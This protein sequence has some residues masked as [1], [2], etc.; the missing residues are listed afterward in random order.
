MSGEFKFQLQ[1]IVRH[2][3]ILIPPHSTG[4]VFAFSPEDL[5]PLLCGD[6]NRVARTIMKLQSPALLIRMVSWCSVLGQPIEKQHTAWVQR[7]QYILVSINI[8]TVSYTHL[9]LPTILLV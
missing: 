3:G 4:D 9:T 6:I 2:G 1:V 5:K 7:Y 8:S